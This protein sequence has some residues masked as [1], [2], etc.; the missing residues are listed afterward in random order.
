MLTGKLGGAE[1]ANTSNLGPHRLL[2]R[3]LQTLIRTLYPADDPFVLRLLDDK[4]DTK[5]AE[6]LSKER[7]EAVKKRY[8]PSAKAKHPDYD[9][10]HVDDLS[11]LQICP[12][13]EFL[14]RILDMKRAGGKR[15][16]LSLVDSVRAGIKI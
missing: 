10:E 11:R 14:L 9:F 13:M 5:P 15:W 7:K 8:D 12:Y 6:E 2:I 3:K 4:E 1:C 16:F